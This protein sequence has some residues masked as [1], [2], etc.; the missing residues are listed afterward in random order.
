MK[1]YEWE[2]IDEVL[3]EEAGEKEIVQ[4]VKDES[5]LHAIVAQNK[6]V[7]EYLENKYPERK[8]RCSKLHYH[9]FGTYQEV[10]EKVEYEKEDNDNV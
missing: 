5:N 8:F 2:S 7:V 1:T 3:Y 9:D 4:V 10:E 6:R